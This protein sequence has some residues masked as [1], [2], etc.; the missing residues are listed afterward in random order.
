MDDV[1]IMCG[2]CMDY[3][4]IM[5]GICMEYAWNMYGLCMEYVWIMYS[6]MDYVWIMYGLCMYLC[7]QCAWNLQDSELDASKAPRPPGRRIGP[8]DLTETSRVSRL[9]TLIVFSHGEP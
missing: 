1:R 3:V 8:G 7:M 4:W 6:S 2:L 9:G 5:Y